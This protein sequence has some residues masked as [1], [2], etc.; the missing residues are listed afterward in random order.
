MHSNFHSHKA[1]LGEVQNMKLVDL[2]FIFML[3]EFCEII[4][5]SDSMEVCLG[6][7]QVVVLAS[8]LMLIDYFKDVRD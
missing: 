1:E 4:S 5:I 7:V 6:L 8:Y 3:K 2:C